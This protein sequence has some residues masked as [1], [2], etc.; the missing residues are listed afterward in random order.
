MSN[1][2][3]VLPEYEQ[4]LAKRAELIADFDGAYPVRSNG[5]QLRVGK[6]GDAL[7]ICA[8]LEKDT[9][10]EEYGNFSGRLMALRSSGNI[11]FASIQDNGEKIQLLI[12]RA[13]LGDES[14]ANWRRLSDL[15]DH[16]I[17][18]GIVGT[19]KTG[20]PSIYVDSWRI[21]SKALK[22]FPKTGVLS[23]ETKVRQRYLEFMTN[24]EARDIM[25]S[26]SS[27]VANMTNILNDADFMHVETPMLQTQRGG[28]SARPFTTHSNAL[29]SDL[30]LRIAPELF[31]KRAVIGGFNKVFEINKNF[32]NEGMDSTHSPE[33][34]MLEAYVAY[35]EYRQMGNLTETL[36]KD[37]FRK[38]AKSDLLSEDV[39]SWF[40]YDTDGSFKN[41]WDW[42]S[43]YG[44][45]SEA[46]GIEITPETSLEDLKE[47]C[48]TH[49]VQKVNVP[50]KGKLVEELWEELVLPTFSSPTFVYGYPEDTSPLV[51]S[52]S[53]NPGVV[54]KWDLY[55]GGMEVATGYSE[56]NDPVVQRERLMA[57]AALSADGDDEAMPVDE[58][59][60]TALEHGMPPTGGIGIGIDRIVMLM[61]GKGIRE[62][63]MFPLVKELNN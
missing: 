42:V 5:E 22:S 21:V 52:D 56:L 57:Q 39:R 13:A 61:T 23:E 24:P 46:V 26:R 20:E 12:S 60:L 27:F 34:T 63:V 11:S 8:M 43:L 3:N 48:V 62:T 35:S 55:I 19:S 53:D 49:G 44:S 16:V 30:Y 1:N 29:D 41:N 10:T 2:P 47:L 59:F 7:S 32:R 18:G 50:T 31:L 6:I 51:A 14:Y 33:F 37:A 40:D 45:L 28:A 25:R 4:R 54:E 15:A 17:V 38:S 58:E 36:L 9:Q